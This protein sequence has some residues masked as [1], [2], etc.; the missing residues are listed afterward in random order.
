MMHKHAHLTAAERAATTVTRVR[1]VCAL[2][3]LLLLLL[4]VLL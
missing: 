4:L 1:G 3:L 2:L